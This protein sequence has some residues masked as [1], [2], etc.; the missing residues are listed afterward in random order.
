[1]NFNNKSININD[2][3]I[4]FRNDNNYSTI[5]KYD[6]SLSSNLSQDINSNNYLN[7]GYNTVNM[8]ESIDN[9][10]LFDDRYINKI[11]NKNLS[12]LQISSISKFN[13]SNVNNTEPLEI[14]HSKISDGNNI[15]IK[16]NLSKTN[17][18]TK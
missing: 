15:N 18:N 7:G 10:N 12:S 13:L 3:N 5:D 6:K 16:N 4:V 14:N 2:E 17:N 9:P 11:N 1:M 8:K